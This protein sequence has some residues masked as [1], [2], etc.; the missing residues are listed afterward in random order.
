[1]NTA[2]VAIMQSLPCNINDARGV[3]DVSDEVCVENVYANSSME[4]LNSADKENDEYV[5][6]IAGLLTYVTT[7]TRHFIPQPSL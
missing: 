1:M 7:R 5:Y 4:G 6:V 2:Q 3:G